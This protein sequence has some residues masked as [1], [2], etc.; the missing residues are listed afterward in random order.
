MNSPWAERWGFTLII[1]EHYGWILYLKSS[2]PMLS[3]NVP[4]PFNVLILFLKHP[5]SPPM[6][7]SIGCLQFCSANPRKCSMFFRTDTRILNT[8]GNGMTQTKGTRRNSKKGYLG[9]KELQQNVVF[10]RGIG[11]FANLQITFSGQKTQRS[12]QRL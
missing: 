1:F 4:T 12:S 3:L 7:P 6:H 10:S 2:T 5:P 8:K 9:V 11:W